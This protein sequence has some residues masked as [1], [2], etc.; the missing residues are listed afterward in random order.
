MSSRSIR[1]AGVYAA[2]LAGLVGLFA[3]IG[4][5]LPFMVQW[6]PFL[7][8]QVPLI[9]FVAVCAL[10]LAIGLGAIT[11]LALLSRRAVPWVIAQYYVMIVRGTPMVVQFFLIFL[12]MPQMAEHGPAWLHQAL[13]LTPIQTAIVGIALFHGANLGEVF[14][15][16]AL[17]VHFGQSEAGVVLGM[18]PGQ[19]ARRIVWPQA[20][21]FIVPP[22]GNHFIMMIKNTALLGFLGVAEMFSLADGLGRQHYRHLELLIVAGIIYWVLVMTLEKLQGLVE[23]RLEVTHVRRVVEFG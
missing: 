22:L 16:G 5:D 7:I 1:V 12:A 8:R 9:L 15:A 21:R 11:A 19:V 6:T 3:L 2:I 14:R 18:T 13:I 23:R 20:V 10:G 4:L 17:S